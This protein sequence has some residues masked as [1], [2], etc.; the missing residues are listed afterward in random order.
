MLG[1]PRLHQR[2]VESTGNPEF[3]FIIDLSTP[4]SAAFISADLRE[5]IGHQRFV[6][7]Q[8]IC[9]T[10]RPGQPCF[11]STRKRCSG[12]YTQSAH[13]ISHSTVEPTP[14]DLRH[15]SSASASTTWPQLF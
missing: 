2:V 8:R 9:G 10:D 3:S 12:E 5:G 1:C 14:Q 7:S 15:T 11:H 13:G 4:R 6:G